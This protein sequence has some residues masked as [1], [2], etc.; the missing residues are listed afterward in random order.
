MVISWL[1]CSPSLSMYL[2]TIAEVLH[3]MKFNIIILWPWVEK[4][5]QTQEHILNNTTEVPAD[6]NS[7]GLLIN[8]IRTQSAFNQTM[9]NSSWS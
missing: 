2:S 6:T 5:L 3:G 4:L 1:H 8:Y 7:G 9:I